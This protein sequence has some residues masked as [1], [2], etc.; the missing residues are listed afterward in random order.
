[1]SKVFF[2]RGVEVIDRILATT[3][4]DKCFSSWLGIIGGC[5]IFS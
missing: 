3:D 1:M 4:Y 2:I 5:Y